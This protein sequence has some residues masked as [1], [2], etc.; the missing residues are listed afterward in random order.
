MLHLGG[1]Q[2][3]DEWPLLCKSQR[4]FGNCIGGGRQQDGFEVKVLLVVVNFVRS[5][6]CQKLVHATSTN[7]SEVYQY[8]RQ[9]LVLYLCVAL[10]GTFLLEQAASSLIMEYSR[11]VEFRMTVEVRNCD[12]HLFV[13]RFLFKGFGC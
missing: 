9:V 8:A 2:F 1:Y 5:S 11:F 10:G 7:A 4:K 6:M 3:W 12:T 13:S